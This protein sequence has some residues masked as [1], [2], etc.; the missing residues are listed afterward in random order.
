MDMAE[1]LKEYGKYTPLI[2]LKDGVVYKSA[3]GLYVE[4]KRHRPDEGVMLTVIE[5]GNEIFVPYSAEGKPAYAIF[6]ETN[7]AKASAAK[8]VAKKTAAKK[9]AASKS[10]APKRASLTD[11]TPEKRSIIQKIHKAFRSGFHSFAE[12]NRDKAGRLEEHVAYW[13]INA[14]KKAK[15][16]ESKDGK[17]K[18]TKDVSFPK[19]R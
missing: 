2:N 13:L 5:T 19:D 9:A 18:F 8:E 1:K 17:I 6:E 16:V 12:F 10:D 14:A 3:T 7:M 15:A 4:V 11:D